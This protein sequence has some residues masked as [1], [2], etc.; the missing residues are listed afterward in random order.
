MLYEEETYNQMCTLGRSLAGVWKMN[1]ERLEQERA[2][3]EDVTTMGQRKKDNVEVKTTK[4]Q[5]D[6]TCI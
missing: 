5:L 3:S 4:K 1:Q 6:S 2:T